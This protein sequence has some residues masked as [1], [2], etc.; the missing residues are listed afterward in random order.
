M[1]VAFSLLILM[2]AVQTYAVSSIDTLKAKLDG[3]WEWVGV[4]D[5]WGV[6]IYTPQSVHYSL[7]LV[8][9]KNVPQQKSD[10]IGY[11][12]Y[13]NDTLILS[14]IARIY[15]GRIYLP[16]FGPDT[17]IKP[18]KSDLLLSDSTLTFCD[19]SKTDQPV[20][21]FARPKTSLKRDQPLARAIAPSSPI[22]RPLEQYTL[23]GR[24]IS[25][26]LRCALPA[27]IMVSRQYKSVKGIDKR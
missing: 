24:R 25:A 2:A 8:F 23:S 12:V 6:K 18:N 5:G 1:R 19:M 27:Q 22:D 9:L 16:T 3:R 15:E 14:G 26:R 10:S 21:S 13:R 20:S 17:I 7:T 4:G 11:Q